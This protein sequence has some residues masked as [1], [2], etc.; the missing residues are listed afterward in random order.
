MSKIELSV[1]EMTCGNCVRHVSEALE[2]QPGVER[3]LVDLDS[4]R[5]VVSG[6]SDPERLIAAL[7]EEGYPAELVGRE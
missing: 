7:Q 3:A 2:K 6:D 4:G 1:S 5:A